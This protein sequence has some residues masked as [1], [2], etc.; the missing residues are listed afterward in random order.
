MQ[1]VQDNNTMALHYHMEM[2]A[3]KVQ[4]QAVQAEGQFSGECRVDS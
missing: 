2:E 1:A 3:L 4:V